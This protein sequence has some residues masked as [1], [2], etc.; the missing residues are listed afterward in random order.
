MPS[1]VEYA[2]RDHEKAKEEMKKIDEIIKSMTSNRKV[3]ET[4]R[5]KLDEGA[6]VSPLGFG[7]SLF[8]FFLFILSLRFAPVNK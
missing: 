7:F 1:K 8:G 6:E 2:L 3:A 5:S 4:K